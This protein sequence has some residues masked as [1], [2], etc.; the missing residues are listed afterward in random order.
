MVISRCTDCNHRD[1]CKHKDDYD[2]FIRELNVQV[3]EPFT[4]V[5]NCKHY[6]STQSY[7]NSDHMSGYSSWTTN[8][9]NDIKDLP[10]PYLP[11]SPEVV[12]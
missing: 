11:G 5:L 10:S 8:Y 4:L 3:P 2:R 7:L 1:I 9:S 12:Y 6:Y